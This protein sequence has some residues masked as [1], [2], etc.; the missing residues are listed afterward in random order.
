MLP[1]RKCGASAINWSRRSMR[2]IL[3][4]CRSPE[5]SGARGGMLR[6]MEVV[7]IEMQIDHLQP[8]RGQKLWILRGSSQRLM[9]F[10]QLVRATAVLRRRRVRPPRFPSALPDMEMSPAQPIE[11][12]EWRESAFGPTHQASSSEGSLWRG[13]KIESQVT[14]KGTCAYTTRTN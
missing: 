2:G 12:E 14:A 10:W 1:R 5:H 3:E 13:P 7:A 8:S 11:Q 6:S 4:L 9:A